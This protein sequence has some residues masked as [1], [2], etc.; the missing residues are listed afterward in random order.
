MVIWLVDDEDHK[1]PIHPFV[2]GND[3]EQSVLQSIWDHIQF[4]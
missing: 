1:N 2:E 4:S 3:Y